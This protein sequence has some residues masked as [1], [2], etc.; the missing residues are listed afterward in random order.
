MPVELEIAAMGERA[1]MSLERLAVC[2]PPIAL[3]HDRVTTTARN[4]LK[5][6]R[7]GATL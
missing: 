1:G 7:A 4:S 2:E 6:F 3:G 5:D